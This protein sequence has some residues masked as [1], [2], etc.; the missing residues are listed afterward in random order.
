MAIRSR[1]APSPPGRRGHHHAVHCRRPR[2]AAPAPPI[3]S[4]A[5]ALP[6][7]RCNREGSGRQRLNEAACCEQ[8]GQGRLG[9]ARGHAGRRAG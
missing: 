8:S 9:K 7:R 2:P 6:A 3:V 1:A 5:A 4:A